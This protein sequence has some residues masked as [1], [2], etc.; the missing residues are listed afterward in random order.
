MALASYRLSST[1]VRV[2]VTHSCSRWNR[3]SDSRRRRSRIR[4]RSSCAFFARRSHNWPIRSVAKL[5]SFG[6]TVFSLDQVVPCVCPGGGLEDLPLAEERR[7]TP[8]TRR[9]ASRLEALEHGRRSVA[10][11]RLGHVDGDLSAEYAVGP[12]A[13]QSRKQPVRSLSRFHCDVLRSPLALRTL[14]LVSSQDAV[15]V[16]VPCRL[17]GSPAKAGV[18]HPTHQQR[19]V[20]RMLPFARVAFARCRAGPAHCPAYGRGAHVV[21]LLTRTDGGRYPWT[22]RRAPCRAL[23]RRLGESRAH[24]KPELATRGGAA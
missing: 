9:R 24:S 8:D 13:V 4:S 14:L 22:S 2:A 1:F 12:H 10:P 3:G 15:R 23:D 19:P 18:T 21:N 17:P 6:F 5:P 16:R 11:A 20:T 7:R